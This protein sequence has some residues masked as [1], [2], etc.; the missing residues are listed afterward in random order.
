MAGSFLDVPH[1]QNEE[2]GV[3]P[4][5]VAFLLPQPGEPRGA[6]PQQEMLQKPGCTRR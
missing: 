5:E 6:N 3:W 4:P 2:A 1:M